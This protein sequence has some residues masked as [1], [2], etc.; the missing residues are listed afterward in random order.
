[1]SKSHPYRIQLHCGT[2]MHKK[3]GKFAEE[4]GLSQ[5][6]AARILVDRGLAGGSDDIAE[7]LDKI[8]L[9]AK[10]T[11]HAAVVSRIMASEAAHKSGSDLQGG[12]LRARVSR[13][14]VR[15]N[16]REGTEQ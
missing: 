14:L 1:M 8:S 16:Q 12:E 13:M 3:I 7:Q 11:L 6:A 4:R 15:Y 10:S 9:L 5:S 2:A